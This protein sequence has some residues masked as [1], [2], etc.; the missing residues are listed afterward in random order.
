MSDGLTFIMWQMECLPCW[1][2]MCRP[3]PCPVETLSHTQ[4]K[5][6]QGKHILHAICP[7]LPRVQ[8][9]FHHPHGLAAQEKCSPLFSPFLG[10]R[11]RMDNEKTTTSMLSPAWIFWSLKCETWIKCEKIWRMCSYWKWSYWCVVLKDSSL[12]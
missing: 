7:W 3:S 2:H 9:T 1:C 11:W 4:E 12:I 10:I 5:L 8:V 6:K